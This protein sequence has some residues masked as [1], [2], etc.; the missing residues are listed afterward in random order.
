MYPAICI[1]IQWC[2][3]FSFGW[4]RHDI[5]VVMI[6]VKQRTPAIGGA[7]HVFRSI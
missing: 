4:T 3:N 5:L 1:L 7:T 6:F 2:M